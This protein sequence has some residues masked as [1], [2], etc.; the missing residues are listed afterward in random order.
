MEES[1]TIFLK[2]CKL[3][4]WIRKKKKKKLSKPH[5]MMFFFFFILFFIVKKA[6]KSIAAQFSRESHARNKSTMPLSFHAFLRIIMNSASFVEGS[7]FLAAPS[8]LASNVEQGGYSRWCR[9]AVGRSSMKQK[10][11]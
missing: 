6:C 2:D 10:G 8:K 4:K 5:F 3:L 11:E 9:T 7:S 1:F